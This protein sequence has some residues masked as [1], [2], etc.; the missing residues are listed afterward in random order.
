VCRE[1]AVLWKRQEID[2]A[3]LAK[4]RWVDN[5]QVKHLAQHFGVGRTAIGN[6]LR[7][8][9]SQALPERVAP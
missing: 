2:L 9:K 3:E 6:H 1:Y 8:L 4:L 7:Q 5:W